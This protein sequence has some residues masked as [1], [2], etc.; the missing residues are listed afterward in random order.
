MKI[1]KKSFFESI[2]LDF[3]KITGKIPKTR[4]ANADNFKGG[5]AFYVYDKSF[6]ET[7]YDDD[8]IKRGITIFENDS[9]QIINFFAKDNFECK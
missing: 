6:P 4:V 9:F 7:K 3:Q 2:K 1:R 5:K 8:S